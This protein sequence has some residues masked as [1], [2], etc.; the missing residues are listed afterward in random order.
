VLKPSV[1]SPVCA[2]FSTADGFVSIVEPKNI[3][4]KRKAA[5]DTFVEVTIIACK[6]PLST[7][8]KP[9]G[10]NIVIVVEAN[11]PRRSG[12]ECSAVSAS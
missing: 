9:R 12:P 1:A 3:C 10:L 2:L 8:K 7:V 4:R 5:F 11:D 6:R